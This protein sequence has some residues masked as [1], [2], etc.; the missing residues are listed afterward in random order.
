MLYE[1]ITVSRGQSGGSWSRTCRLAFRISS[2][3]CAPVAAARHATSSSPASPAL[4]SAEEV[5]A[6]NANYGIFLAG[7]ISYNFV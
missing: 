6:E 2:A 4:V 7:K 3:A 1:V 5:V